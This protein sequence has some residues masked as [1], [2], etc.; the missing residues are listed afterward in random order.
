MYRVFGDSEGIRS[1]FVNNC[2]ERRIIK[3]G[4]VYHHDLPHDSIDSARC[5]LAINGIKAESRFKRGLTLASLVSTWT[6]LFKSKRIS[7]LYMLPKFINIKRGQSML[8]IYS[9][10]GKTMTRKVN[11]WV[12]SQRKQEVPEGNVICILGNNDIEFAHMF[13]N[14]S[15][16]VAITNDSV[17]LHMVDLRGHTREHTF[18]FEELDVMYAYINNAIHYYSEDG[19]L[20]IHCFANARSLVHE[21]DFN[22]VVSGHHKGYGIFMDA[23]TSTTIPIVMVDYTCLKDSSQ[24]VPY[25]DVDNGR[26]KLYNPVFIQPC[27]A[28]CRM[29]K[30]L[31]AIDKLVTYTDPDDNT[32]YTYH[33]T[34]DPSKYIDLDEPIQVAST[35][36]LIDK[37]LPWFAEHTALGFD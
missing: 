8:P 12:V 34:C 25:I 22:V 5:I 17:Q 9:N 19:V 24:V 29:F 27:L 30:S 31:N 21:F 32:E 18:T 2:P 14:A 4:D 36:V 15:N 23:H 6:T 1:L 13:T 10:R 26:I 3:L 7:E 37:L 35:E 33:F 16:I 11:T 20:Y 28:F